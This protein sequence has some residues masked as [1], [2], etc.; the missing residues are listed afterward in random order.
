MKSNYENLHAR[1]ITWAG[2]KG[3]LEYATGLAQIDKTR[4]EVEETRDAF[5]AQ[6]NGVGKFINAKG[7]MKK[8]FEEIKDGFGDILVTVFIGCEL[9]G[10][11]PME[12][13][14]QAVNEIEQR[15][16][17]MIDGQF[18]KDK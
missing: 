4:E 11:D 14:E 16:G 6:R 5:L 17:K 18:V 1:V 9:Q 15:T 3:I 12:C 8:T 13:L 2:E 10:L 7:E